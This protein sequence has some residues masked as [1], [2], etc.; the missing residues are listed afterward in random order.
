MAINLSELKKWVPESQELD[1][2]SGSPSNEMRANL[3]ELENGIV[4]AD[5]L[6]PEMVQCCYSAIWLFHD[7]LDES[8]NISQ[9]IHS[10]AGSYLHGI[11]HRREGDYSNAKY[12]FRKSGKQSWFPELEA[13]IEADL[14]IEAGSRARFAASFDP[15]EL[16]D[17]VSATISRSD[18]AEKRSLKRISYWELL[19]IFDNCSGIAYPGKS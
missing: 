5:L 11:M 7:F 19:T 8:H 15:F 14:E 17:A 6:D 12:W 3:E 1:L 18:S 13:R 2:G 4:P 16:V 10:P 9:Q